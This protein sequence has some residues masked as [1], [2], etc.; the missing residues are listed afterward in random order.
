[1]GLSLMMTRSLNITYFTALIVTLGS[2]TII[3]GA[4][5]IELG[6]GIKPCHLCL[7]GRL[8]HYFGIPVA[9]VAVILARSGT[10]L[11]LA[12][13]L[14]VLTAAIFLVG[15]GISVYHAGVEFG[16]FQGPTDCTGILSQ[17]ESV[18]EFLK[19]LDTVKIVRCDEVAMRIFGL[20][21]AAWNAI[22]CFGLTFIASLGAQGRR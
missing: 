8:P 7:I 18:N 17:P 22:I 3:S 20:S 4:W 15:T 16:V 14:L 12:R 5:F 1:M 13:T 6:L 21:L 19:Q 11:R 10:Q 9:A 2:L